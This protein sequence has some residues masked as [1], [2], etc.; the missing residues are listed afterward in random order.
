[1]VEVV[2]ESARG[3][4]RQRRLQFFHQSAKGPNHLER[5][6]RTLERMGQAIIG[7]KK[8]LRT[9]LDQLVGD[10]KLLEAQR[11]EQRT[12]FDLEMPP[13]GF[14]PTIFPVLK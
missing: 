3:T 14:I 12:S 5:Q 2:F 6:V 8:E 11:L 4:N 13:A 1:M 10:G 9:R 7:I